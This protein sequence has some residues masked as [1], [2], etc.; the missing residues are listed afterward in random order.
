MY[1]PAVLIDLF[2]LKN[3]RVVQDDL[4]C[5]CISG[6]HVDNHPSL[7]INLDTGVFN[8]FVCNFK[9]LSLKQLGYYVGI[10]VPKELLLQD[11]F[12]SKQS[13]THFQRPPE[14]DS[15]IEQS[16]HALQY[17]T[18]RGVDRLVIKKNKIYS[19]QNGTIVFP[20]FGLDGVQVCSTLRNDSWSNRFSYDPPS[21]QRSNLLYTPYQY[22][23]KFERFEEM[24]VVEGVV[25][26]LKAESF[27]FPAAATMGTLVSKNQIKQLFQMS[28]NFILV[29][30]MDEPGKKWFKDMKKYLQGKAKVKV[31]TVDPLYKDLGHKE[32]TA[33]YFHSLLLS[34]NKK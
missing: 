18:G 29:P 23:D 22:Q 10:E 6:R 13:D 9:G 8:C 25:D 28:K 34:K 27:G 20:I 15:Y 2:N 7:G 12:K 19:H 11:V 32:V 4:M 33:E 14:G 1:N 24:V 31:L 21:I 30:D 17:L 5:S 3:A 26:K 16:F